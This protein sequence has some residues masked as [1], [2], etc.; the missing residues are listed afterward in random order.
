MD[1]VADDLDSVAS[2]GID[3]GSNLRFS[4][5]DVADVNGGDTVEY[6]ETIRK[7]D[8]VEEI[9]IDRLGENGFHDSLKGLVRALNPR[10]YSEGG[11][12]AIR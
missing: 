9:A 2:V 12:P 3:D 11:I 6:T 10:T 1:N 7:V 5:D 4:R 8:Q